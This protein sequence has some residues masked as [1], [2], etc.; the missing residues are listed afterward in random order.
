MEGLLSTAR[1]NPIKAL[2]ATEMI[3]QKLTNKILIQV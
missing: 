2:T 1:I 3:Q